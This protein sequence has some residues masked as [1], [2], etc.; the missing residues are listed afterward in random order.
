MS[1]SDTVEGNGEIASKMKDTIYN[2]V[3]AYACVCVGVG[4]MECVHKGGVGVRE[5]PEHMHL[6]C[7]VK[8]T[9]KV[10]H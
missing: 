5:W 8:L 1:S 2:T 9:L 4:G 10:Q 7:S 3:S 6:N